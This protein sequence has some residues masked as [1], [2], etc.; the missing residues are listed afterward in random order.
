M[1]VIGDPVNQAARLE[2][3]TKMFGQEIIVG[4]RVAKH[5][6]GKFILRSLG[7][8]RTKGKEKAEELFAVL[9]ELGDDPS[10]PSEDWLSRY[11]TALEA[12]QSGEL[13][14]AKAG[15]ERCVAERPGD[16]TIAMY[17]E[18]IGRGEESGVLV[19]TG[20]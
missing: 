8:V 19:M 12:F 5:L 3:L 14:E 6:V 2:G 18:A 15:L 16:K 20:K 9:G 4:P 17:L 13:G 11:H 7:K 1:T 10:E